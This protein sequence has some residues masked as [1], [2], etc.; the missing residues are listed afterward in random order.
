MHALEFLE[1]PLK[2]KD[3]WEK[4]IDYIISDI[5]LKEYNNKSKSGIETFILFWNIISA[6][7]SFSSEIRKQLIN[8][9]IN[10]IFDS[11]MDS[12][13]DSLNDLNV[14]DSL[15]VNYIDLIENSIKE[16][17]LENKISKEINKITTKL[18]E[19]YSYQSVGISDV[20][21]I[22][23]V[24]PKKVW[25]FNILI[26]AKG[27]II[28]KFNF[29]NN[30]LCADSLKQDYKDWFKRELRN[31]L[32]ANLVF[33]KIFDIMLDYTQVNIEKFS[34][35]DSINTFNIGILF[36]KTN[37]KIFEFIYWIIEPKFEVNHG[38]N[39]VFE[40]KKI[41]FYNKFNFKNK[42]NMKKSLDIKYE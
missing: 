14:L 3:Y 7:S 33:V 12:N 17:N 9:I 5:N 23:I 11:E 8:E 18:I 22:P 16:N 10:A 41:E 28:S 26:G 30:S 35:L 19:L 34:Y 37:G 39:S 13:I 4:S 6:K 36:N 2:Y 1:Q 42:I 27:S 32:K 38:N 24:H 20:S 29:Y 31:W 15:G 21:F 25:N 40:Y